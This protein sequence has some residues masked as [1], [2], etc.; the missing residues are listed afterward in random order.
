V[1]YLVVVTALLAIG[2]PA[3]P[4]PNRV[5][6][7]LDFSYRLIRD[8]PGTLGVTQS[9]GGFELR[10]RTSETDFRSAQP[11][12]LRLVTEPTKRSP[13][14]QIRSNRAGVLT[15]ELERRPGEDTWTAFVGEV[16][17]SVELRCRRSAE[18][19]RCEDAQ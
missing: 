2:C 9:V 17:R 5:T 4:G 18:V 6:L 12:R 11:L 15:V 1:R 13:R 8:E 10:R 19:V 14:L 3:E 16:G 7:T